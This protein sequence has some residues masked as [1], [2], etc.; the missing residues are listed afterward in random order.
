MSMDFDYTFTSS[1]QIGSISVQMEPAIREQPDKMEESNTLPGTYHKGSQIIEQSPKPN[2]PSNTYHKGSQIT[3]VE[4]HSPRSDFDNE[5]IDSSNPNVLDSTGEAMLHILSDFEP[6]LEESEERSI[7][8]ELYQ[9]YQNPDFND[10][11]NDIKSNF[12]V[13]QKRLKHKCKK[14]TTKL[15]RCNSAPPQSQTDNNMLQVKTMK[16]EHHLV[17]DDQNH[18]VSQS[19]IMEDEQNNTIDSISD[20]EMEEDFKDAQK[21][22]N[23]FGTSTPRQPPNPGYIRQ[24]ANSSYIRQSPKNQFNK[25]MRKQPVT[26]L[27]YWQ[28]S[29]PSAVGSQETDNLEELFVYQK[30]LD[31]TDKMQLR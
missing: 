17:E 27:R 28:I 18:V 22:F 7:N 23:T 29:S 11:Y 13:S 5:E 10:V 14:T 21:Y 16:D 2:T 20:A 3:Q 12:P 9:V 1:Q 19:N 26:Q 8:N 4:H 15:K 25:S 30:E 6:E 24:S 31:E